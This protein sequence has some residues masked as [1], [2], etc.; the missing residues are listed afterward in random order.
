[1]N[2]LLLIDD[3][4]S[5]GRGRTEDGQRGKSET[6]STMAECCKGEGAWALCLQGKPA[7]RQRWEGDTT[8][9]LAQGRRRRRWSR[10]RTGTTRS[11]K[12]RSISHHETILVRS[13]FNI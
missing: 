8:A 11:R 9:T 6:S 10:A 5:T 2:P 4:Q 1:M 13:G 12:T 3:G 7:S